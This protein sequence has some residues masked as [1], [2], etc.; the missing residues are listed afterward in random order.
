MFDSITPKL[1]IHHVPR[2]CCIDCGGQS[3]FYGIVKIVIQH[4]LKVKS[5]CVYQENTSEL[6][7]VPWYII[8][9]YNIA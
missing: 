5:L 1:E 2:I 8:Q 4:S 9:L 7:D 6:S 3:F